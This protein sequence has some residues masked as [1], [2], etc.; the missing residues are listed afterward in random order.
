MH[1]AVHTLTGPIAKE[2]LRDRRTPKR[3]PAWW[4]GSTARVAR[5]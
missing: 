3:R 4:I 1:H 5:A 2:R